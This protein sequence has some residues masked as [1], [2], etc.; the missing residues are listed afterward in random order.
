MIYSVDSLKID[1]IYG[2]G[3]QILDT[4]YRRAGLEVR[5]T[6]NPSE[7]AVMAYPREIYYSKLSKMLLAE[8]M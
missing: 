6:E 3:Q 2:A 7:Y 5:E 1:T 8:R 4:A